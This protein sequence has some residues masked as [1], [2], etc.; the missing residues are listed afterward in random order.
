MQ[1]ALVQARALGVAPLGLVLRDDL[2]RDVNQ[3]LLLV[4]L[5]Q[6][7]ALRADGCENRLMQ[8]REEGD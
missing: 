1:L 8:G 3:V 6:V 7:Q 5:D 4:V 2:G